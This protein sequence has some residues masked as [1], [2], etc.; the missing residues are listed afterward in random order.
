MS[1]SALFALHAVC[2]DNISLPEF[3]SKETN[4]CCDSTTCIYNSACGGAFNNP[5]AAQ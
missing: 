5:E 2:S 4:V 1:L 3:L